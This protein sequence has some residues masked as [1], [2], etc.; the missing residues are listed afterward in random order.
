MTADHQ[1]EVVWICQVCYLQSKNAPNF[2]PSC[3]FCKQPGGIMYP[4]NC[5]R[6]GVRQ[7]PGCQSA[8]WASNNTVGNT[9]SAITRKEHDY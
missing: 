3:C 4:T 2:N 8:T 9:L 7:T 6:K 5:V 1:L